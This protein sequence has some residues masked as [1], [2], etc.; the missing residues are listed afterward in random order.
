MN[1]RLIP[2]FLAFGMLFLLACICGSGMDNPQT[3]IIV[4][5][6]PVPTQTLAPTPLPTP[7]PS[8]E[9]ITTIFECNMV[10]YEVTSVGPIQST[11]HSSL[12]TTDFS[13]DIVLQDG[14]NFQMEFGEQSD[15]H[16][17][18]LLPHQPGVDY[19][20]SAPSAPTRFA[21]VGNWDTE[22][23]LMNNSPSENVATQTVTPAQVTCVLDEITIAALIYRVELHGNFLWWDF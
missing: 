15:H 17:T 21:C 13:A 11:C 9:V 8:T 7:A 19:S 12:I 2:V 3:I 5:A 18:W 10:K 1:K 22:T 20:W 16:P 14:R 6:T 4:Q 23:L